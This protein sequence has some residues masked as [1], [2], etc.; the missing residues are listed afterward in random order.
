MR[1]VLDTNIVASGLLWDGTPARLFDAAQAGAIEIYTSRILLTELTRIFKRAKFAKA[2]ETS[3]VGLEGLVLG[4]SELAILIEP[5]P[6]PPTILADPDDDHVLACALAADAE[7]IVSGD[8]H[9]LGLGAFKGI[10]I[11]TAAQA[12]ERIAR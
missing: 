1:L 8:K 12:V 3:G 5:L 11:I 10:E 4:Y 2:I 6:I 7:L 9:L